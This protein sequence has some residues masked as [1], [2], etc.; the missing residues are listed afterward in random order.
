MPDRKEYLLII[1]LV[2]FFSRVLLYLSPT[3]LLVDE[4]N[5]LVQILNF[6]ENK[7]SVSDGI[8]MLPGYHFTVASSLKILG[9]QS[10][11]AARA[12]STFYSLLSIV[13]FYI[14]AKQLNP[15]GVLNKTLQYLFCP[16]IFPFFFLIYTDIMSVLL[17]LVS[18]YLVKIGKY[19]LS[20]LA[21]LASIFIRQNNIVWSVFLVIFIY[22]ERFG[23]TFKW[24][25]IREI[26][27]LTWTHFVVFGLFA[28]FVIINKGISTGQKEF[29]PAMSF[30]VDNIFFMLIVF[31]FIFLPYH[32]QAFRSI[33]K[34]L[35]DKRTLIFTGCLFVFYMLAFQNSHPWNQANRTFNPIDPTE[36]QRL[37][38][39]LRNNF[40][41]FIHASVVIKALFFI[42][43]ACSVLYLA[44]TGTTLVPHRLLYVFVLLSL[45]PMWLIDPRYYIIPFVFFILLKEERTGFVENIQ[46][47]Y[48]MIISLILMLGTANS[49]FFI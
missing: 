46:T 28:V 45:L 6:I 29:H 36:L 47:A 30:H 4:D 34:Q 15:P 10:E 1:L 24:G 19:R 23:L 31:F 5:H 21:I 2:I 49:I 11:N 37:Y 39:F 48:F 16:I 27:K 32:L 40:L 35:K 7:G 43:V 26:L 42:P 25:N 20:G 18:L 44:R 14:L 8:S 17:V 13:L 3:P 41:V 33:V 9:L 38:P 22:F 12:V